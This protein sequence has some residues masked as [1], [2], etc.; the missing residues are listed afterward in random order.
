MRVFVTGGS[1]QLGKSLKAILPAVGHEVIAPSRAEMDVTHQDVVCA[2]IAEAA[3]QIVIHCA[4]Y[5]QVDLA[6]TEQAQCFAVNAQGT[7]NVARA[8]A[9]V[10]IRM[11]FI[12]T[13][14][15]FDGKKTAAY[16]PDDKRAPLSVYGCSKMRG[17]DA[18]LR[19][20]PQNAVI[21][22]SWLFGPSQDNFVQAILRASATRTKLDVVCDQIGSPTYSKDLALLL[23]EFIKTDAAGIFHAAN[24]GV[25]SRADYA[26]EIL[27]LA[28]RNCVVHD[29]PT[30]AYPSAA[31]RPLNSELST[32]CL[33]EKGLAQLPTWQ[34]A[35]YRYMKTLE[36]NIKGI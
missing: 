24:T 18:V 16:L 12:S 15:V 8:C 22:T 26:R 27:R 11:I 21:R 3:A 29:V 23:S 30:T 14:Y 31:S 34:D 17:E 25:C 9:S 35:L 19:A 1:G 4:A 10:G 28:G 6:E 7:E 36:Q 13:D 2:R 33:V 20:S 5:N 32:A